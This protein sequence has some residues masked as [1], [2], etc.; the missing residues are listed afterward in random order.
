MEQFAKEMLDGLVEIIGK[1]E[2]ADNADVQDIM[3]KEAEKNASWGRFGLYDEDELLERIEMH[4]SEL[5]LASHDAEEL[6]AKIEQRRTVI[7]HKI[8][9]L[10]PDAFNML[11]RHR[12]DISEHFKNMN[13]KAY[14]HM[15]QRRKEHIERMEKNNPELA[16]IFKK[17]YNHRDNED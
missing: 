11:S 3:I 17:L 9:K 6:E 12:K 1:L 15:V 5:A 7:E 8:N 13:P 16:E 10:N 2:A 4:L 14:E